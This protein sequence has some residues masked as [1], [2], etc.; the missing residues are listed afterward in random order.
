LPEEGY[1]KGKDLTYP[2]EITNS[3]IHHRLATFQRKSNVTS[4]SQ[5]MIDVS[6]KLFD[7]FKNPE[8]LEDF[9]VPF[10]VVL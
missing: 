10:F 3:D 4:R 2:I 1:F 6:L 9:I 8:K 5:N 7:Y